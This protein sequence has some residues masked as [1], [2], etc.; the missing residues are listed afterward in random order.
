MKYETVKQ[1]VKVSV[2]PQDH[3]LGKPQYIYE[4]CGLV[5]PWF[6]E[7]SIMT[8]AGVDTPPLQEHM[9]SRYGFGLYVMD[10]CTI[11]DDLTLT[12]PGDPDLSPLLAMGDENFMQFVQY[13]HA[14]VAM[15]EKET[16]DWFVTRMD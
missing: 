5:P 4:D 8:Q 15:R 6:I 10:G 3:F 12:Y 2:D 14:I 16:D 9:D 11:K 7:W 13:P 1:G